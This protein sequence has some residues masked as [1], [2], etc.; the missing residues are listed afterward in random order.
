MRSVATLNIIE[1]IKFVLDT[2]FRSR[3]LKFA[4]VWRFG[5]NFMH[6]TFSYVINHPLVKHNWLMMSET[7]SLTNILRYNI[8]SQVGTCVVQHYF[9]YSI[10][11]SWS[12]IHV[13]HQHLLDPLC[14]RRCSWIDQCPV[15]LDCHFC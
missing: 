3:R 10:L 5:L 12:P 14:G 11:V 15:R 1:V 8:S 2:Y 9:T 6:F 7:S 13:P 4:R